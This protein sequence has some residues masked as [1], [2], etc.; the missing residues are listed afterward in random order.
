MIKICKTVCTV[1]YDLCI[2]KYQRSFSSLVG[3]GEAEEK[4]ACEKRGD[5]DMGMWIHVLGKRYIF[6]HDM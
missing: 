4:E 1:L 5:E 6:I 2:I 3:P